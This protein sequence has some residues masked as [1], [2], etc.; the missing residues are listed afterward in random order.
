MTIS[1]LKQ[2]IALTLLAVAL[3]FGSGVATAAITVETLPPAYASVGESGGG[4][5]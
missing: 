1:K 4:G 3:L 5:C 2:R